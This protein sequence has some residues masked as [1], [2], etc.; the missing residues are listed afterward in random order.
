MSG[1][2]GVQWCAELERDRQQLL[3][4]L[5]ALRVHQHHHHQHQQQHDVRDAESSR[6]V[7][8]RESRDQGGGGGGDDVTGELAPAADT[9]TAAGRLVAA[10]LAAARYRDALRRKVVVA[11]VIHAALVVCEPGSL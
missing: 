4:D 5:D 7:T 10:E 2:P 1:A 3:T 8:A 6:D 9:D 11:T